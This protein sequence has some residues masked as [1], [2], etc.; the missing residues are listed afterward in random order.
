M[1]RRVEFVWAVLAGV[2][3]GL[4]ATL[5]WVALGNQLWLMGVRWWH[6]RGLAG[7]FQARLRSTKE[8]HW[9]LEITRDG[10]RLLV[11]GKK[12][13]T[14]L[15]WFKGEIV[16][17]NEITKRGRGSYAQIADPDAF[18]FWEVQVRDNDLLRVLETWPEPRTERRVVVDGYLWERID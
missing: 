17:S 5:L 15:E 7:K 9:L 6:Y 14:G 4:V 2:V 12:P 10:N 16:M 8:I 1:I 11:T 13:E 18:G 3:G